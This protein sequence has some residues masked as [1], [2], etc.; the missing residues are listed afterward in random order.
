MKKVLKY[1]LMGLLCLLF[2]YLFCQP[3]WAGSCVVVSNDTLKPLEIG[4]QLPELVL[5]EVLN[6]PSSTLDLSQYKGKLII[7][8]FWASW[9]RPCIE[10]FPKNNALQATFDERV[11]II[12]VTYESAE[13]AKRMVDK[14]SKAKGF[15]N[16]LP[17]VVNEQILHQLFPHQTL[18]H[19]VWISPKGDFIQVTGTQDVTEENISLALKNYPFKAQKKRQANSL[20]FD[21]LASF[22]DNPEA[23]KKYDLQHRSSLYPYVDGIS[24]MYIIA[25]EYGDSGN[26]LRYFS[27]NSTIENLYVFAYASKGKQIMYSEIAYEVADVNK[28]KR[29][30][31]EQSMYEWISVPGHAF[32]YEM[33]ISKEQ[34][35]QAFDYIISDLKTYFPEYEVVLEKRSTE[36][37]VLKKLKEN[38][39]P[40]A[41]KESDRSKW[42]VKFDP[43]EVRMVNHNMSRLLFELKI[44][45]LQNKEYPI[46][47]ET[48]YTDRIDLYMEGDLS[49]PEV[50][51]GQLNK[52]GLTI[53]RAIREIEF[54]V[55]KD[56][57][58]Q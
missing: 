47:D 11:Q 43:F 22:T 27:T 19:Y 32:N 48:G 54:L 29:V 41:T 45:Y 55:F 25:Q 37:W 15:D 12:P 42:E 13:K 14:V 51:K 28:L 18:P 17:L 49:N 33:I 24:S 9:C 4:D 36:V 39:Q 3:L 10:A 57:Q 5:K 56:A 53:E 20:P 40:F 58:N 30:N 16:E 34:K 21:K 23:F 50:L 35:D 31:K 44:K 52:N 46:L 6:H 7:L 2:S 26:Q 38:E 8:D 1:A